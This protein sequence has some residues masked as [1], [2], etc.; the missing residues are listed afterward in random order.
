MDDGGDRR[1][2][3]QA[4]VRYGEQLAGARRQPRRQL[5]PGVV[6]PR[7][8][9]RAERDPPLDRDLGGA[10]VQPPVLTL[11]PVGVAEAVGVRGQDAA[12]V[13][14][15]G[16]HE[17]GR[18][19][20]AVRLDRGHDQRCGAHEEVRGVEEVHAVLDEDATAR[21]RVPEPVAGR[22]VLVAGVVL[23][24]EPLDRP[25]ELV[26][27]H[28]ERVQQ[29]VV[30][31]HVVDHEDAA[32]PCCEGRQVSRLGELGRQRLLTEDVLARGQR[33]AG[34]RCVGCSAVSRPRP[35]RPPGRRAGRAGRRLVAPSARPRAAPRRQGR[36]R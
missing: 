4:V 5:G 26:T 9:L 17:V 34:D 32:G 35:R 24:R 25:E 3:S 21:L 19:V 15:R 29:R 11:A 14:R 22:K 33:G 8:D 12:G 30:A 1:S 16:T 27:Q 2:W 23:E 20:G 10:V 18:P 6:G 31:Q 36:R 7:V 28:G 13:H